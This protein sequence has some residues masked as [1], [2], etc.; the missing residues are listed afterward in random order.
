[1]ARIIRGPAG[2]VVAGGL[3]AGALDIT[4]ACT[5]WALARDVPAERILQSVAS[6]VLGKA[7]YE[8]G[9]ATALLGL[10]LHFFITLAMSAAY[11]AVSRRLPALW[12]RPLAMGAA[13]GLL[14][15]GVMNFVVVPLS[16]AAVS[17]PALNLWTF[18]GIAAHVLLVGV[19][20][21]LCVRRARPG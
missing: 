17:A 4:F 8:G 15:Y 9:G 16:N 18:A 5:Y 11:Y 2:W 7:S 13:Y 12:Q 1:M 21:A 19:P 6:G 3:V 10:A 14:L 20:I